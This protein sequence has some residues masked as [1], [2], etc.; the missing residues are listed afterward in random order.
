MDKKEAT[1]A[2]F[3]QMKYLEDTTKHIDVIDE[4]RINYLIANPVYTTQTFEAMVAFMRQQLQNKVPTVRSLEWVLRS[5][6]NSHP[7]KLWW[8]PWTQSLTYY[9]L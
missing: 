3:Q 2:K 1:I 4:A 5:Q 7:R 6:A 9:Y 8:H